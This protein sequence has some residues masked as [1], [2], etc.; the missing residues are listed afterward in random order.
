MWENCAEL[1][2]WDKVIRATRAAGRTWC[3][4]DVAQ[5]AKAALK[6]ADIVGKVQQGPGGLG[7]G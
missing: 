3:P 4:A 1:E 7:T 6:H 2:S 5:P